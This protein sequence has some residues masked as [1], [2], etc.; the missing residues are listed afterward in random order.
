MSSLHERAIAKAIEEAR[1][2]GERVELPDPGGVRGL[3]LRLTP[4]GVASWNLV[5]KDGAGRTRRFKLGDYPGLGLSAARAKARGLREKIRDG[6]DPVAEKRKARVE[7]EG[8]KRQSEL[9]LRVLF[10][11]YETLGKGRD[12]KS[13]EKSR[14]RMTAIFREIV[15]RPLCELGL[16][17]LQG[18]VDRYGLTRKAS[19]GWAVRTLRPVLKWGSAPGRGLVSRELTEISPGGAIR[20]RQRVLSEDELGRVWKTLGDLNGWTYADGM[21]FLLLTLLRLGEAQNLRW[22]D[23]DLEKREA[24]IAETKNGREHVVPLS[25]PCVELLRG[26]LQRQ[27]NGDGSDGL[28][29]ATESGGVLTQWLRARKIVHE[30]SGTEGWHC[31]DLRRTGA[32]M[33]GEMGVEPYVIEAALNHVSI[34]SALAAVYNVSR[35]RPRVREALQMLGERL[36]GSENVPKAD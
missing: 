9:T 8:A 1:S 31:H 30:K 22:R 23:V 20:P 17:D 13:W 2:K 12:L 10:D 18:I 16:V 33:L 24:R 3:R 26:R 15:D 19:A 4:S 21:R 25:D 11:R 5:C 35:Y 7:M 6:F 32:T 34:H 14:P 28:V 29:F 27:V 36:A